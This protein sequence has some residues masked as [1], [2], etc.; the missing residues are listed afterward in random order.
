MKDVEEVAA[1]GDEVLVEANNHVSFSKANQAEESAQ[2]CNGP[3][4]TRTW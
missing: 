4:S 3:H 1:E 2:Q